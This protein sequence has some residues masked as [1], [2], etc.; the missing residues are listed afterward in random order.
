MTGRPNVRTMLAG[1]VTA[2]LAGVASVLLT[3]S[4]LTT[5]EDPTIPV[6]PMAESERVLRLTAHDD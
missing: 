4:S 3:L 1:L 6:P 2:M 5:P